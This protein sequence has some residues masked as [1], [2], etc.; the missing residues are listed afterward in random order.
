MNLMA[1]AGEDSINETPQT[2]DSR[3]SELQG[4]TPEEQEKQKEAWIQELTNV[5]WNV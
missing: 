3:I 4:L 1:V 2:P 5:S